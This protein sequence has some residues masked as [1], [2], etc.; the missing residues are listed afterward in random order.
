M[1]RRLQDNE[2]SCP[3]GSVTM[4][5]LGLM[6]MEH[7]MSCTVHCCAKIKT[8]TVTVIFNEIKRIN[9][10][11]KTSFAIFFYNRFVFVRLFVS[12]VPRKT[13]TAEIC[14]SLGIF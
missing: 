1:P 12:L 2:I 8:T 7:G 4:R 11:Q 13:K 5:F 10:N 9:N 14:F 3:M 6:H